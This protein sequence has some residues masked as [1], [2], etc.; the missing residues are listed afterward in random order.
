[1]AITV[2]VYRDEA[3]GAVVV[4]GV[5][6]GMRFNNELRAVGQGNGSIRLVNPS[7]ADAGGE[8]YECDSVPFAS[9]TDENGVQLGATEVDTVNALNAILYQTGTVALPPVITSSTTVTVTDGD[10]VNYLATADRGVAYEWQNLPSGIVPINGRERNVVGV[11]QGGVGTYNAT[12]T[13]VNYLG[14]D[15]ETISF[16]VSAPPFSNTKSVNFVNNDYL[17]A[18]A[19]TGNPL[20]RASQATATPWTV[21]LWFKPGTS[22]N[23]NQTILSFGG[24]NTNGTGRVHIEYDGR[25]NTVRL[26]Y[27]SGNANIELQAPDDS[28]PSGQWVHLAFTYDGGAADAG[29]ASYARFAVYVN[30]VAASTTNSN[31]GGG[32]D[33]AIPATV[34][35]VGERASGGR[36]LRNDCR[37][38]EL[39]LW[40]SDEGASISDLYNGGAPFDLSTLDTPPVNWWRMGD[41]DTYPLLLDAAGNADFTM[42][43][44]TA[45]EIVNDTP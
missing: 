41:G 37:V 8:F 40:D 17:E 11:I 3:A 1:M 15:I 32:W 12:L 10:P 19:T 25:D 27:G 9:Y 33:G 6:V 34:F 20:Y 31:D 18:T 45:A 44:M 43:N 16:V 24:D 23:R 26:V 21:A 13:A 14:V 22:N 29:A 2:R 30:G 39:A 28:L 5:P 38:D 36:H 42:Y 7:R 35:R 4:E